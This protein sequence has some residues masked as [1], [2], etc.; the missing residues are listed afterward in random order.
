[1]PTDL[2]TARELHST[3]S[4]T[5]GEPV[6]LALTAVPTSFVGSPS[7]VGAS[8]PILL[9]GNLSLGQLPCGRLPRW[10]SNSVSVSIVIFV[11]FL[12]ITIQC[13]LRTRASCPQ[14]AAAASGF[15]ELACF[16]TVTPAA[17]NYQKF[18][19]ARQRLFNRAHQSRF[20][21][22]L[23][24][25]PPIRGGPRQCRRAKGRA[26]KNSTSLAL[27]AWILEGKCCSVPASPSL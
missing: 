4:S 13:L 5:T 12:V 18:S 11:I 6:G 17:R 14:T 23:Q 21:L 2:T 20:R 27:F 10:S 26:S 8:A 7:A 16:L 9:Q 24:C 19:C 25:A 1:M 22:V 3:S 15:Y